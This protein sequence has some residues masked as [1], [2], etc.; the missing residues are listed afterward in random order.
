MI[1]MERMIE[2]RRQP[3]GTTNRERTAA[4]AEVRAVEAIARRSTLVTLRLG[5]RRGHGGG[6]MA[7]RLGLSRRTL[8]AWE[9]RCREGQ[10]ARLR[11]RPSAELSRAQRQEVE[12]Y[13]AVVGPRVSLDALRRAFPDLV[14]AAL[15]D[16]RQEWR[17]ARRSGEHWLIHAL[18]WQEPGWVWAVDFAEPPHPIDGE[19]PYLLL[20]RDLGSGQQLAAIPCRDATARTVQGVLEALIAIHG[21]PLVIKWDN[22][23]AFREA[24]LEALLRWLGILLLYSPPALPEYNGA[25]EAGVGSIKTRTHH[26]AARHD[27]PQRW[28]SDDVEAAR[29]QANE[30]ARPWGLRG[31]TRREKFTS[32]RAVPDAL[33]RAFLGSYGANELQERDARGIAEGAELDHY[34]QASIDRVAIDRALTKHNILEYRR[35]RISLPFNSHS[36]ARIP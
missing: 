20:V 25:C 5:R 1:R 30:V 33:R 27:R 10:D 14:P 19:F 3:V 16:L 35:R 18:R 34:E 6:E 28:T 22:D 32:G 11:G 31:P 2:A 24:E 15:E 23:P 21:A 8:C 17:L 9:K 7:C 26:E 36:R 29:R 12:A 4:Q 13:V